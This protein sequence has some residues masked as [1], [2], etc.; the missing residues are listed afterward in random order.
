MRSTSKDH[1]KP[2]PFQKF[3]KDNK[4]SGKPFPKN[5]NRFDRE[6]DKKER[7]GKK[8]ER[9]KPRKFE[10]EDL[11]FGRQKKVPGTHKARPE[12]EITFTKELM[13]KWAEK[14]VK[15]AIFQSKGN[16]NNAKGKGMDDQKRHQHKRKT[17]ERYMDD[18][19]DFEKAY[20]HHSGGKRDGQ[21]DRNY[22]GAPAEDVSMP[23]NKF[24]AH[25]DV[26]G[27]R[28]AA[29]LVREGK[30]KVN[31]ELITEP[32]HKVTLKDQVSLSG[33]KLQLQ[34]NR[35]YVLMNKPKGFITT[36]DD[37]K[38]RRTVMDLVVNQIDERIYPVGRLDR[39]TTGLLLLTNDGQLAQKLSHPSNE[40]KKVY[41]VVLDRPVS[42]AD[43]TKIKNGVVLE[44]GPAPVNQL[45][46]L[47]SK[48]EIGLE[49][50]NGRNRIVR[51][52]FE[53]LGY[54][55]EKL[56]RVVYAGLTKKNIPRGKWRF[57]SK[58]EVIN[59]KHLR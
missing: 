5:E 59:L 37:P 47:E 31:G 21:E 42:E 12:E 19:G 3:Y 55:V 2:K 57:L 23:L 43:F 25:C 33:K 53:S 17:I 45:A 13:N 7:D 4:K 30:V 29:Q 44:D 38:G 34:E 50:H 15:P 22:Y 27:R 28:E 14:P 9:P 26:C 10:E 16:R 32:G 51:R 24:I 49:I 20:S 46:Y 41:Q 54:T 40:I 48:N 11:S 1:K 52:I 18:E 39:N 35:I 56:D 58:Q 8:A 36:M 6:E